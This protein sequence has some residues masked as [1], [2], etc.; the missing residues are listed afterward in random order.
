[1]EDR[2]ASL[3]D[4]INQLTLDYPRPTVWSLIFADNV[5]ASLQ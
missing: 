5:G 1:M 3:P 2:E 4:Y